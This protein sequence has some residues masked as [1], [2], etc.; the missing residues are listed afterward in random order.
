MPQQPT[1]AYGAQ[2]VRKRG[3]YSTICVLESSP[4]VL[5]W[6]TAVSEDKYTSTPPQG[7]AR[8]LAGLMENCQYS[9]MR[10]RLGSKHPPILQIEPTNV[11]IDELHLLLRIGDVL[12][13]NVILQADSL[14]NRVYHHEGRRTDNHLRTLELLVRRCGVTF[15]IS[16]V[17]T[18][19]HGYSLHVY[20][21]PHL[22]CS[23]YQ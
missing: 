4:T 14:D 19:L 10:K 6:D 17:S 8:T 23:G 1:P 18:I 12:L 2:S 15:K 13:R 16:P 21:N 3:K 22:C 20:Q 9:Q 11:I 7:K 5:R